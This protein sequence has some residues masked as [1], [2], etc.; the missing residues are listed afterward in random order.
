[1]NLPFLKNK[2]ISSLIVSQRNPDGTH[3]EQHSEGDEYVGLESAAED[4]IRA[5]HSKDTQGVCA[6]LK[7]AFEICDSQPH[8]E[9]PHTNTYDDMNQKAGE[10]E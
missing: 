4:L 10:Q 5:V 6:A 9:G 3:D 2:K 1:M 8:E 7:A